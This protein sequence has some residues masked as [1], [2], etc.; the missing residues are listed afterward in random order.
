MNY[1][2][3]RVSDVSQRKA[4]PAQRKKL[5]EYAKKNKWRENIDF[6]YIEYD[7]TAYKGDRKRF[8][9][10]VI[11]PLKKEK[12]LVIVVFDKIDRFSRDTS[13]TERK[14]LID[15]Y[16][17]GLVE[18]H[19][20]SDGLYINQDSPAHD[21]FRL[22]IGVALAA[23]Y[24]S[25]I[26][27][28]VR[29]RFSEM[30]ANGQWITKAPL[31]YKNYVI[32]ED[33]NGGR[34]KKGVRFDETRK[35]KVHE[36]YELRSLGW[37]YGAIAKKMKAD[38][39]MNTPRK[40]KYGKKVTTYINKGKWEEIL[41]NPF[42]IGKMRYMGEE[43][44]HTY[45]NII[46]P[47]L[48][49]KCQ[50]V[51]RS[52]R[53]HHSKYQTKPFLFKQLKCGIPGC[54]CTVTFDGPKGAG[55]NIYG[56]CTTYRGLHEAKWVNEKVLIEQVKEVLKQITVPKDILPD[57]IAEI[58]KNHAA[59]QEYYRNLKKSLQDEH[60][61]LDGDLRQM[62]I[63]REAYKLRMDIF[64]S[65]V[66][67]KTD[68]QNAILEEL[69]DLTQGNKGFVIG[70][71]YILELC[72]RAVELFEAETTS[73]EQKRYLIETV[74]SNMRLTGEKLEFTLTEP[75]SA[76]VNLNKTRDWCG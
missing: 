10:L 2:I 11:E 39:L 54:G 48:W 69:Q 47:W 21:L 27:D 40:N 17:K 4:L 9:E 73:I 67:E 32:E 13:S 42:Y 68:R 62:F 35:D 64:G 66:K 75:F 25:A 1:L 28:N 43:Y 29:R 46:E 41:T 31:G 20:P 24:S 7:E 61:K 52:R 37:S 16:K 18:L 58:E 12:G 74:L 65:I 57:V 70:A 63:D 38:G 49:D 30:V 50:L 22:D 19:F 72:S 34:P 55:M 33:S 53:T 5:Y 45:G 44:E 76:L 14:A 3:A 51:N 8:W 59:E 23:Y 36:A 26:R 15:L 56:R 6:K 71:T 60:E